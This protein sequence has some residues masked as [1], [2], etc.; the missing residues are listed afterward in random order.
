M[1]VKIGEI[2]EAG[3][4]EFLAQCYELH[5][6]PSLG[7]LVKTRE[8]ETEIIAVVY[9]AATTSIEP[10][11]RPV[12]LGMG[13]MREE[14]IYNQ[15][16]QLSKLLRTDFKALVVGHKSCD[17][18]E[19]RENRV[20]YYLPPRPARVHAFVYL[21]E[22]DETKTFSRSLDFLSIL[23]NTNVQVKDELIAA[24]LRH[25]SSV[26]DESDAFLVRAGKELALLLGGEVQRLNTL[27]RRLR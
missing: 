13:E 3:T 19:G 14:D 7:S 27:L 12:A 9:H 23:V 16:P 10:G 18:M 20:R 17:E 22:A 2:I 11:R 25:I 21:C 24:C 5:R 15:N 4:A 6:P 1:S 8:E 26:H